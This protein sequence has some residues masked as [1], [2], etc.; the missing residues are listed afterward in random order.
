MYHDQHIYSADVLEDRLRERGKKS[1][2]QKNLEKLKSAFQ[3]LSHALSLIRTIIER[4]LKQALSSDSEDGEGEESEEDVKPFKGARETHGSLFGSDEET[5][6]GP[7]S[8]DFIV[9]DDGKV[10]L[11]AQF[12]METHQ[13]LQHQLKKIFQFFV[14]IA[15]QRP[16]S[17]K[18]FME[19]SLKGEFSRFIQLFKVD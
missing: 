2:F 1:E 18:K 13:D 14:H 11:P 5:E 12:S 9:E 6:D 8:D 3:G 4:K 7:E 19:E 15:V 17:R 16:K 10:Q